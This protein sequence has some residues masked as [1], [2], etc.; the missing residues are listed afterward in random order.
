MNELNKLK[1]K[2]EEFVGKD[3]YAKMS[4]SIEQRIQQAKKGT[5]G[6]LSQKMK[7]EEVKP[8]IEEIKTQP[9]TTSSNRFHKILITEEKIEEPKIQKAE[10]SKEETLYKQLLSEGLVI[11]E[12]IID[13]LETNKPNE[14]EELISKS[15]K[16]CDEFISTLSKE[17]KYILLAESLKSQLNSFLEKA[18]LSEQKEPKQ[19]SKQTK[20][21][22]ERL[23]NATKIAES[24]LKFSDFAISSFGFENAYNSMKKNPQHFFEFLKYFNSK[25]FESIFKKYEL[26]STLLTAIITTLIEN[27]KT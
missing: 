27:T 12:Q 7:I 8:K 23:A 26:S 6:T 11:R 15:I 13:L 16:K 14:A 20:I 25:N 19:K 3:N 24:D 1:Q 4:E 5:K 21:D 17:S 18:K 9:T 10:E 2:W 22:L